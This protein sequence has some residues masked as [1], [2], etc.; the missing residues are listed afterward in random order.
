ME[1]SVVGAVF[2]E[3]SVL[4]AIGS[5]LTPDDF[6]DSR[7]GAIYAGQL[8]IKARGLSVDPVTLFTEATR[9][10]TVNDVGGMDFVLAAADSAVTSKNVEAHAAMVAEAASVRR[11]I[12]KLGNLQAQAKEGRYESTE[13]LFDTVV[14]ESMAMAPQKQS[15]TLHEMPELLEGHLKAMEAAYQS[16]SAVQGLAT[17]FSLIDERTSGLRPGQLIILAARPA[18]GKT[19]LALAMAMNAAITGDPL[20]VFIASLEMPASQLV[21]RLVAMKARVESGKMRTGYL[22]DGDI[23]RVLQAM[24]VLRDA[25]I[26]IDDKPGQSIMDIRGRLR[27]IQADPKK[28]P[29]GLVVIDY[30]QLMRGDTKRGREQEISGISRESKAMSKEFGVPIIA[31]SQLNRSLESRPNKRPMMSDLRESGAIEQDADIIMFIYRDEVYNEDTEDEGIAEIITGKQREGATG[32]DR[33]KWTKEYA[34]FS[35]LVQ[36]Y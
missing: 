9:L 8:D 17:G 34:S 11:A 33:V 36:E 18:M 5:T 4:D 35:N 14:A 29:L 7:L 25:S 6:S 24:K 1:E 23:D 20:T 13:A 27:S 10:N 16:K 19:A 2:M 31:L 12:V 22:A 32:I 15:D 21:A 3:P 30:L 28:P 26:I